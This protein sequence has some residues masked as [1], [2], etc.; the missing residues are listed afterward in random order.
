M[1]ISIW[2]H[3]AWQYQV[4]KNGQNLLSQFASLNNISIENSITSIKWTNKLF[5]K[6]ALAIYLVIEIIQ[7]GISALQLHHLDFRDPI[8]LPL[9]HEIS[10]GILPEMILMT[11]PVTSSV[12]RT[13][14]IPML[15]ERQAHAAF[16]PSGHI[17][18]AF[19]SLSFT[20]FEIGFPCVTVLA[21]LKL[22][23]VEDQAGLELIGI[24]LPLPPKCWV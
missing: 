18:H 13:I 22:A 8:L 12:S 1:K 23:L 17:S 9:Q 16:R 14:E 3:R 24:H 19:L 10:I 5:S 21:V 4:L 11:G 2:A 15:T 7:V 6:Q 20:F